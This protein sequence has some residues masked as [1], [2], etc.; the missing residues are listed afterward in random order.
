[1]R[2]HWPAVFKAVIYGLLIL[3]VGTFVY[4]DPE[5]HRAI[6]QIGWL[7]LLG[8]FEYETRSAARGRA[9]VARP[10]PLA[11]EFAGYACA[12]YALARYIDAADALEIANSVTWLAI[13]AVIWA[14][15]LWPADAGSRRHFW[16]TGLKRLLYALTLVWGSIWGWQGSLLDFY[17][18]ALWILCFFG[19]ELNLLGLEGLAGGRSTLR[20]G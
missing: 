20:R 15:I 13:S 10:L 5:P 6:D 12:V 9:V 17:D 3:N 7:I 4:L 16:R 8:V 1:M 19:I 2:R 11:F 14:D 18:A